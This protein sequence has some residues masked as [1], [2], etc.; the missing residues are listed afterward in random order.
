MH[1]IIIIITQPNIADA[2]RKNWK[3]PGEKTFNPCST[4]AKLE[5]YAHDKRINTIVEVKEHFMLIK[6]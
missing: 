6:V 4:P 2:I 1:R 5:P 3:T